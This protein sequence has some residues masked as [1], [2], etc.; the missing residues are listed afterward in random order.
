M[1]KD[2]SI[3]RLQLEPTHIHEFVV[4][5]DADVATV[6]VENPGVIRQQILLLRPNACEWFSP[7]FHTYLPIWCDRTRWQRAFNRD[8]VVSGVSCSRPNGALYWPALICAA[9]N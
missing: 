8:R 1:T 6:A 2:F 5:V 4:V 3:K 7:K 9:A